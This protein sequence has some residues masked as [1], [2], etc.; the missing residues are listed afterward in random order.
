MITSGEFS[1]AFWFGMILA[2]NI[3]PLMLMFAGQTWAFALAG[4]LILIGLWFAET[5]WVKAPQRIPLS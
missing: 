3:L 1:R 5:I 2:G 4:V